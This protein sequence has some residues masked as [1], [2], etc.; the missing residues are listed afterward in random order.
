MVIEAPAG[1]RSL[2]RTL[3]CLIAALV[4]VNRASTDGRSRAQPQQHYFRTSLPGCEFVVKPEAPVPE[5]RASSIVAKARK[6][7]GAK[8]SAPSLQTLPI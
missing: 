6:R 1:T 8:A 7:E 4:A 3:L 5:V 2:G